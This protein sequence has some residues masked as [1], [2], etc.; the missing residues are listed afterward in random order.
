MHVSFVPPWYR[1]DSGTN[2]IKQEGNVKGRPSGLVAQ[3]AE[4]SHGKRDT[5]GSSPGRATFFPPPV[6]FYSDVVECSPLDR[7]VPGSI[8]GQGIEICFRIRDKW[9]PA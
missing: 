8:V 7:R 5:L 6:K 4:C 9:R 3:L 2:L 1:V